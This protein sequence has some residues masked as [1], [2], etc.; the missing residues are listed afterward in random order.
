MTRAGIFTRRRCTAAPNDLPS[1]L[2]VVSGRQYRGA[3]CPPSL[4]PVS[5]ITDCHECYGITQSLLSSGGL[6][7][8]RASASGRKEAS[9]YFLSRDAYS[10]VGDERKGGRR[11][12]SGIVISALWRRHRGRH[13]IPTGRRRPA[14]RYFRCRQVTPHPNGKSVV[15]RRSGRAIC[16]KSGWSRAYALKTVRE[17]EPSAVEL[18]VQ[19][20]IRMAPQSAFASRGISEAAFAGA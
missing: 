14:F 10:Q 8:V 1:V 7:S 3:P 5:R 9:A 2:C 4:Q 20:L 13:D 6:R 18:T 11:S 15:R 17:R 12:K 16:S 19:A